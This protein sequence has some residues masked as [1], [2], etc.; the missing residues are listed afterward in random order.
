MIPTMTPVSAMSSST[1][2]TPTF[3]PQ[4]TKSI[5]SKNPPALQQR[6]G[7]TPK[8]LLLLNEQINRHLEQSTKGATQEARQRAK[9]LLKEKKDLLNYY[10]SLLK[11]WDWL[12]DA[13]RAELREHYKEWLLSKGYS[14]EYLGG[15]NAINAFVRFRTL[16]QAIN[17]LTNFQGI[18][19]KLSKALKT[20]NA[21]R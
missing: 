15:F 11:C 18:K 4:N 13:P 12:Y 16:G 9:K 1:R 14:S 6:Q 17:L 21:G 20:L 5:A 10:I 19:T 8:T 7:L 2:L 3:T